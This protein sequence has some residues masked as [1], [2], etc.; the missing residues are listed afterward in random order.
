MNLKARETAHIILSPEKCSSDNLGKEYYDA[1]CTRNRDEENNDSTPSP[2]RAVATRAREDAPRVIDR[3]RG[4]GGERE[5]RVR[6][7]HVTR[8]KRTRRPRGKCTKGRSR[9]QPLR[10]LPFARAADLLS[11]R[12]C[13]KVPRDNVR[14]PLYPPTDPSLA[15]RLFYPS[16]PSPLPFT[17]YER[18]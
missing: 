14:V 1:E 10:A 8:W 18:P 7:H 3:S 17:L 15:L 2:S 4:C 5:R 9:R 16:S 11:S 12:P 6:W 13:V